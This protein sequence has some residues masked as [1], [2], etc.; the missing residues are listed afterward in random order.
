V[1]ND[2]QEIRPS[3]FGHTGERAQNVVV[4]EFAELLGRD[5]GIDVRIEDLEEVPETFALCLLAK[6]FVPQQRLAVLI[7]LVDEGDRVKAKVRSRELAV[8]IAVALDLTALDV[9]DARAAE[10]LAR[11]ARVGAV[12]RGPDVR[13][14]IRARRRV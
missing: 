4:D 1:I 10:R 6:F 13:G 7:E 5:A 14:V 12:P 3:R 11:L 9:I 8:A 2:L